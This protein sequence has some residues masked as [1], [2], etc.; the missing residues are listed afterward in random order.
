MSSWKPDR[1]G[2]QSAAKGRLSA[3]NAS[4]AALGALYL[5][6]YIL[7]CSAGG[8]QFVHGDIRHPTL[9]HGGNL[10]MSAGLHR[11]ISLGLRGD[12]ERDD[13]RLFLTP[14]ELAYGL[15]RKSKKN[16]FLTARIFFVSSETTKVLRTLLYCSTTLVCFRTTCLRPQSRRFT[17]TSTLWYFKLL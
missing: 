10:E 6:P 9:R 4:A 15:D 17:A 14:D 2:I 16:M 3:V 8:R 5:Q 13:I 1:W 11:S 12:R 7:P